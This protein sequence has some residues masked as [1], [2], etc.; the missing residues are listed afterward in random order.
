MCLKKCDYFIHSTIVTSSITRQSSKI[1]WVFLEPIPPPKKEINYSS[2]N[3]HWI[4]KALKTRLHKTYATSQW[5]NKWSIAS[6]LHQYLQHQ[7]AKEKPQLKR[8]SQVRIFLQA[9]IQTK[10]ETLIGS[11]TLISHCTQNSL[12][13]SNVFLLLLSFSMIH[14]L[15]NYYLQQIFHFIINKHALGASQIH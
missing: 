6:P 10:N 14:I 2:I 12:I 4:P 13:I 7:P 3:T 9:A 15:L 5:I 8:L 11:L 1:R